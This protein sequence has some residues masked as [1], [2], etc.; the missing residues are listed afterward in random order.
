MS[1]NLNIKDH[2]N[3]G[4]HWFNGGWLDDESREVNQK[5]AQE[6]ND[7]HKSCLIEE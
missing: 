6:Y 7:L 2:I 5:T 1:G 3:S 4:V